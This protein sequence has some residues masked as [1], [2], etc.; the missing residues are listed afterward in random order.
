MLTE[1]YI[2]ALLVDETQDDEVWALW[3]LGRPRSIRMVYVSPLRR[4]DA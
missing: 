2:E 4:S 3:D 1:L